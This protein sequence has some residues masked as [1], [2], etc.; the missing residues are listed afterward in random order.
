MQ[1]TS[2]GFLPTKP[3]RTLWSSRWFLVR[4]LACCR[5]IDRKDVEILFFL[6]FTS[7]SSSSPSY[8]T[9]K[10]NKARLWRSIFHI[11]WVALPSPTLWIYSARRSQSL[12]SLFFPLHI[13]RI[14]NRSSYFPFT[15]LLHFHLSLW[16]GEKRI[17]YF[18][19]GYREE[20]ITHLYIICCKQ[21]IKRFSINATLACNL[22]A[23]NT[24]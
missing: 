17:I 7:P 11:R 5:T 20:K 15:I 4:P 19:L 3:Q 24:G 18:T 14:I 16:K 22:T 1:K 13:V 9:E 2:A 6:F 8:L 21:R 10:N 23:F 12:R